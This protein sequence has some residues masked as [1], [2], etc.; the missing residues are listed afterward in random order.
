MS[1]NC[2]EGSF[3][4]L[5]FDQTEVSSSPCKVCMTGFLEMDDQYF[6]NKKCL[7]D[8]VL[9]LYQLDSIDSSGLSMGCFDTKD[10]LMKVFNPHFLNQY[11]TVCF[12]SNID[13]CN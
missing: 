12:C 5:G 7:A 3:N 4:S 1:I 13:K 8:S 6:G 2:H 11:S 10:P 9:S